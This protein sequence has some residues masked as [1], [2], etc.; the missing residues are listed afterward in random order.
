MECHAFLFLK[1]RGLSCITF[2]SGGEG[3]KLNIYL[4]A[5]ELGQIGKLE[6]FNIT[7]L[8]YFDITIS[9]PYNISL[10]QY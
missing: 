7:V 10:E 4:R 9:K 6:N 5:R 8:Q 1:G 2:F 3:L